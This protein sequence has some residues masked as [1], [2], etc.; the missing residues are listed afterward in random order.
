MT[1]ASTEV[2][3]KRDSSLNKFDVIIFKVYHRSPINLFCPFH[4]LRPCARN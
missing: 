2:S 3:T 4:W 1:S